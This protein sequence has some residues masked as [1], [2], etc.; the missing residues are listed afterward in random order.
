VPM[1]VAEILISLPRSVRFGKIIFALLTGLG[2]R[3]CDDG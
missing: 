1:V 2:A 3:S